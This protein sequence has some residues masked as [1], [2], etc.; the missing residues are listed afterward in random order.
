M[1]SPTP[2]LYNIQFIAVGDYNLTVEHP[3]FQSAKVTGIHV[4]INQVCALR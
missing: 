4:D 2:G 1:S 3:G